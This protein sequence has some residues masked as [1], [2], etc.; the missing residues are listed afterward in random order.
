MSSE[1]A[2]FCKSD[3]AVQKIAETLNKG[4]GD[5]ATNLLSQCLID[6]LAADPKSKEAMDAFNK[7]PTADK[8]FDAA[9]VYS[10]AAQKVQTEFWK[11]V[12]NEQAKSTGAHLC[13]LELTMNGNVATVAEINKTADCKKTEYPL[14]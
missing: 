12:V 4:D 9:D 7:A 1:S 13:K 5:K 10:A 6:R 14:R 3:K 11:S 2:A 8:K